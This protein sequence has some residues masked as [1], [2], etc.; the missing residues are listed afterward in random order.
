MLYRH[1]Q[2]FVEQYVKSNSKKVLVITGARQIGKSYLIRHV[3]KTS[4]KHYVEIN[5]LEDEQGVRRFAEVRTTE[6]FYFQLGMLVGNKLG[7]RQDTLVF[8]DEIQAYPHL[9]TLLKF[10]NQENRYTYIASGSLLG[11]TLS[12]TSSIPMGSI[13]VVPMYPLDFEEFLLANGFGKEAI[14]VLRRKFEE[15]ES[16]DEATHLRLM[17]LFRKYLIVGGL[18]EVVSVYVESQNIQRVRR[19]QQEIYTYYGYDASKYD[20]ENKLKIKRIYDLIPSALEN[21]KKRMVLKDI[22]DKKGK[23]FSNYQDEFDY[24]ISAGIALEVRAVSEPVFPLVASTGKNLLKLYLNDVGL[25]TNLL[26][27][28]NI[29]AIM[30]DERS[31]NL[32]AVYELVVASELKAHGYNLYYYDNKAK[33]EVD[34]LVDDYETL[35]VLP[36]EVKSGRDYTIHSALSGFMKQQLYPVKRAYVFSNNRL[37]KEKNGIIYMPVYNVMFL[38]HDKVTA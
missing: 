4:F 29:Q 13:E 31:V 24:L 17:D 28:N 11:V 1:I 10:L 25:L 23:R 30:S 36:I 20:T 7:N 6:D 12:Q 33:G 9:L 3:G 27:R 8:L 15:K 18:P 26:F 19:L 34:Y 38:Q 32:G 5:L 21:K 14:D 22:E 35:S 2:N 16:L 37:I